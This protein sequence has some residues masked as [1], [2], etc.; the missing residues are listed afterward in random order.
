MRRREHRTVVAYPAE[1]LAGDRLIRGATQDLS[2]GGAFVR[3]TDVLPVGALVE[4]RLDA[5]RGPVRIAAQVAH[6]LIGEE[7]TQLGRTPGMGLTFAP[8]AAV[9][10]EAFHAQLADFFRHSAP[11]P[12]SPA[13][14]QQRLQSGRM[15]IVVA[16]GSTRLL[17]RVS[18]ALAHAGFDVVTCTNGAEAYSACLSRPPDVVLA[19]LH[20]PVVGGLKLIRQLGLRPELASIPVA[21]MSNDAGDLARLN[22]YQVGA[23]DFI[24]KPFTVVEMVIRVRRLARLRHHDQVVLRGSLV[25]LSLAAL[26]SLFE[27]EHKT[28]VLSITR[29]DEAIWL[30]VRDGRVVRA[31]S[32]E[33]DTDSHLVLRHALDLV[34]GHFE[35]AVCDVDDR[36]DVGLSTTHLLLEHAR[37]R[38][39]QPRARA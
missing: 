23:L 3:A 11:T 25:E 2:T 20:M 6:V 30:S 35:F 33:T 26:L 29:G 9:A 8:A 12:Q 15:R 31:R 4:L 5:G 38:D 36:D 21:I 32:T 27:L 16:D 37:V 34:D 22:A 10:P 18:A 13:A 24:P 17:E 14:A 28:G 7:A 19:A 39:E 1:I